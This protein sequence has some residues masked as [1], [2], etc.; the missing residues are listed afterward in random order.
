MNDDKETSILEKLESA[1]RAQEIKEFKKAE[2][3]YSEALE[4]AP[5]HSEVN[6]RLGILLSGSQNPNRSVKFLKTAIQLK[7]AI[8]RYWFGYIETLVTLSKPDSAQAVLNQAIKIGA[9]GEKFTKLQRKIHDS[10]EQ[11]TCSRV[12]EAET[13]HM[14]WLYS[15]GKYRD[16]LHALEKLLVEFPSSAP[17]YNLK[18][19][20]SYKLGRYDSAL[21]SYNK[22][23]KID[24]TSYDAYVNLGALLI[25]TNDFKSAIK[26]LKQAISIDSSFPESHSNLGLA[27]W[28]LGEYNPALDC[29]NRAIEISPTYMQA[30]LNKGNVY[31]DMDNIGQAIGSYINAIKYAPDHSLAYYNIGMVLDNVFLKGPVKDLPEIILKLLKK[32]FFVKSTNIATAVTSLMT[33]D[34]E[35]PEILQKIRQD[36]V[37]TVLNMA[38]KYFAKSQALIAVM[39]QGPI[40][41]LEIESIFSNIRQALLSNADQDTNR[42]AKIIFLSGLALHCFANE[43]VYD[44]SGEEIENLTKLEADVEQN[45]RRGKQPSEVHLLVL[46]CYRALSEYEWHSL[47][48]VPLGLEEVFLRH[49]TEPEEEALLKKDMPVLQPISNE[50]SSRVR[51]QYEENPYPRW[52]S[53][54]AALNP[55]PLSEVARSLNLNLKDTPITQ[56][57]SPEILIAGCG[58]GQHALNTALRIKDSKLLAIDLSLSSLA[59]AKRKTREAGIENIKYM[60]ADILDLPLLKK[61][62]DVIESSGVLHH[63]A[64]PVQGW[65][66]LADLLNVGG[67]MKISLYSQLARRHVSKMRSEISELKLD[68]SPRAMRTFRS[69]VIKS[70]QAHHKKITTSTDF[71]S[72]SEL[73]DL[74]F[75]EE[76]HGFTIPVI[77][78]ILHKLGLKFCGFEG[79]EPI[80]FFRSKVSNTDLLHDLNSWADLEKQYP[81]LFIGMYQF[82]CQKIP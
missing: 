11:M 56:R 60:Q 51:D 21:S 77:C 47:L 81:D 49:I 48:L 70:P 42:A 80:N 5:T 59:Y 18:G 19:V 53:F 41:N 54:R 14:K 9:D 65:R 45:L 36:E 28:S 32:P 57:A 46:M 50:T 69:N 64:D 62:F 16:G 40:P 22:A 35:Y 67:L 26:Y 39:S 31:K 2:R 79:N 73:R 43:Y 55:R 4:I 8:T 10:K 52:F 13:S 7:P 37:E 15:A 1:L 44:V 82:W 74:L 25:D 3:L 38:I 30:H 24:S 12:F 66:I 63:M 20:M 68:S 33:H 78:K 58:T 71:Y 6:Y 75:H 29:L 27:L 76:E 72:L 61:K 34:R 23:I 17:L